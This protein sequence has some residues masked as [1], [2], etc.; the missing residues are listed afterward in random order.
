MPVLNP[1]V[2]STNAAC[3]LEKPENSQVETWGSA[4]NLGLSLQPRDAFLPSGENARRARTCRM[5]RIRARLEAAAAVNK[6]TARRWGRKVLAPRHGLEL[7]LPAS[8]PRTP[9]RPLPGP[10][11]GRAT[12]SGEPELTSLFP[13]SVR[14]RCSTSCQARSSGPLHPNRSPPCRA[15]RGLGRR[16]VPWPAAPARSPTNPR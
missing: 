13:R 10:L 1:P 15:S 7:F 11:P 2:M 6:T 16:A 8:M 3:Q 5:W 4:S 12:Y 14:S 9:L